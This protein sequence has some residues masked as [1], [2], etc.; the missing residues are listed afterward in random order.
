M[1]PMK[2]PNMFAIS[3]PILGMMPGM[4]E[5]E[6]LELELLEAGAVELEPLCCGSGIAKQLKATTAVTKMNRGYKFGCKR[7]KFKTNP[8]QIASG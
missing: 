1:I 6:L 2:D 3:L 8:T 4:V 7:L 5:L